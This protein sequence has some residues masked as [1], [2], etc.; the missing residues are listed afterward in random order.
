MLVPRA[1]Q[2]SFDRGPNRIIIRDE[3][4]YCGNIEKRR[5]AENI[6]PPENRFEFPEIGLG[7]I[8]AFIHRAVVHASDFQRQSIR[9][10][11]DD[12]VGAQRAKFPRQAV[13]H[14]QRYRERCCR[15]GHA[16]NKRRS[17]QHLTA[18][19]ANEGFA[20]EAGEHA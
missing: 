4:N 3:T 5:K 9:F 1:D 13:A 7:Q 6:V 14:F 16:H 12:Q 18:R 15:D 2:G 8:C 19:V 10:G 11:R 17:R 20:Y